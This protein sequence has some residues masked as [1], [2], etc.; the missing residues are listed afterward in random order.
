TKAASLATLSLAKTPESMAAI[1]G[2]AATK[3]AVGDLA[4]TVPLSGTSFTRMELTWDPADPTHVLEVH[5][6]GDAAPPHDAAIRQKLA[7]L[8]GRRFDKDGDMRWN[9]AAFSYD[10]THARATADRKIV[11]SPNPYWKTQVDATWDVL[12]S[13]VLELPVTVSEAEQRDW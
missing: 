1:T 13:V 3:D 4:M 10:G 12:R 11:T 8:L 5:L 6:Y 2:Q 9:G 7:Q